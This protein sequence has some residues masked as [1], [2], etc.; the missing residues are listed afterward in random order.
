MYLNEGQKKYILW[1]LFAAV[2]CGIYFSARYMQYY[3]DDYYYLLFI[4]EG[5]WQK[6]IHHYM[7]ENGRAIVHFL[8]TLFLN[9]GVKTCAAVV[10]F[11]FAGIFCL[12]YKISGKRFISAAAG[13]LLLTF[14]IELTRESV[15]WTTGFFNY[16]YPPLMLLLYWYFLKNAQKRGIVLVC[17]AALF[18]SA[19]TEQGATAACALTI[20]VILYKRFILKQHI[21]ARYIIF[22][23]I[24]V[25]GAASVFFAP[26]TFQRISEE[27]VGENERKQ[28]F[29]IVFMVRN[30]F[31][32]DYTLL[33]SAWAVIVSSLYLGKIGKKKAA[34]AGVFTALMLV[35]LN[36]AMRFITLFSAFEAVVYAVVCGLSIAVLVSAAVLCLKRENKPEPLFCGAVIICSSAVIMLSPTLGPRVMLM[37]NVMYILYTACLIP[38]AV[39][40]K[41]VKYIAAAIIV[42]CALANIAQ[43]SHGYCINSGVYAENERLIEEYK[44]AGG[45]LVQKRLVS[46]KYGWS[47]PYNSRYH[48]YYYKLYYG[49]DSDDTILWN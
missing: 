32:G 28:L 19:S 14:P 22:L 40:K 29:S 36:K 46:E 9:T 13:G 21:E 7:H 6:H 34:I 2:F 17:A 47:M 48:E 25:M 44:Q 23:A 31:A 8:N 27:G 49:I 10:S 5:F 37:T 41:C 33:Q 3:G 38:Y 26:G 45:D 35:F 18:A 16:V 4:R 1:L 11:M 43:T 42:I 15:Y 39:D 20:C 30:T 24:S 12:I